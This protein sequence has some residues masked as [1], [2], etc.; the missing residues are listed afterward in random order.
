MLQYCKLTDVI[1]AAPPQAS[2]VSATFARH[3]RPAHRLP[4]QSTKTV[5]KGEPRLLTRELSFPYA[6]GLGDLSVHLP[7]LRP[8]RAGD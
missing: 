8:G 5:E 6:G 4:L 2:V 3:S 1:K 7:G